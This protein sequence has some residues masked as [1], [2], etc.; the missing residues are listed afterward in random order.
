MPKNALI[1][2]VLCFVFIFVSSFKSHAQCDVSFT[3]PTCLYSDSS[4]SFTNT[5]SSVNDSSFNPLYQWV[6]QSGNTPVYSTDASFT[7]SPSS[8]YSVSLTLLDAACF[9]LNGQ[10]AHPTVTHILNITDNL[11]IEF[12]NDTTVAHSTTLNLGNLVS[13]SGGVP[14]YNYNWSSSVNN[15][16]S[17]SSNPALIFDTLLVSQLPIF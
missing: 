12:D 7:F 6:F 17:A 13:V 5:S 10:N 11:N 9:N 14:P 1:K 4:I 16:T 2:G 15:F 3:Y 8:S